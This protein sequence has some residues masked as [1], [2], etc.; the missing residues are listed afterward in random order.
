MRFDRDGNIDQSFGIGWPL[1]EP[2]YTGKFR[3][4]VYFHRSGQLPLRYDSVT[5]ELDST[6]YYKVLHWLDTVAKRIGGY[7]KLAISK[8]GSIY[9]AGITIFPYYTNQ[10]KKYNGCKFTTSGRVDTNNFRSPY[11]NSIGGEANHVVMQNDTT[12]LFYGDDLRGW[13]DHISRG[14]V[15][16]DTFGRP[17][18]SF[19]SP[20]Y[21]NIDNI[22][23]DRETGKFYIMGY[24][25]LNNDFPGTDLQN[26]YSLMRLNQDGSIDSTFNNY[27]NTIV[28]DTTWSKVLI[29]QVTNVYKTP[30][31]TLLIVGAINNYQGIEC[32]GFIE[33]DT[34]GYLIP[35]ASYYSQF[36]LLDTTF[37]PPI[38]DHI[39]SAAFISDNEYFLAGV[40]DHVNGRHLNG[41]TAKINYYPLSANEPVE[42]PFVIYPNPATNLLRLK[43]DDLIDKVITLEGKV[44]YQGVNANELDVSSLSS[45]Y[46]IL[47]TVSGKHMSFIKN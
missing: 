7:G 6:Y 8:T 27:N 14:I 30:R 20:V 34:N 43:G 39:H 40:F 38:A 4:H 2:R 25:W 33:T 31:N 36:D 37:N 11:N 42:E 32:D 5:F 12:L 47:S 1:H 41:P 44:I 10:S 35:G 46:Y 21:G 23:I 19:I 9:G 29:N 3:N 28:Y 45:G 15:R 16:T 13:E 26:A 17:D 24:Y 18:T 22:V